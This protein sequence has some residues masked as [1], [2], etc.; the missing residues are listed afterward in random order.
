M[1]VDALIPGSA[2]AHPKEDRKLLR[3]WLRV[4]LPSQEAQQ[5]HHT[6][7]A[8]EVGAVLERLGPHG[9][10]SL[11][12]ADTRLLETIRRDVPGVTISHAG[13]ERRGDKCQA[14]VALVTK[15]QAGWQSLAPVPCHLN[16]KQRLFPR[17]MSATTMV[18]GVH[19]PHSLHGTNVA[20][21]AEELYGIVTAAQQTGASELLLLGDLNADVRMVQ[22]E[23]QQRLGSS[24][25]TWRV[26]DA[27]HETDTSMI[28][29][30]DAVG[31]SNV[32]VILRVA[33]PV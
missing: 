31:S 22:Q 17:I 18:A 32:D 2:G 21:A 3:D 6:Y 5:W 29:P 11:Q 30:E 20:A 15:Q 1:Y 13:V 4:A 26:C 25:N 16:G 23:L 7:I 19:I 28:V 12:E 27:V 9:V 24:D 14:R 8:A 33:L 10:V